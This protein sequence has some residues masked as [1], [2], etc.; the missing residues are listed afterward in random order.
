MNPRHEQ[1]LIARGDLGFFDGLL[2]PA[3]ARYRAALCLLYTS[4]AAEDLLRVALGGRRI[5][6]IKK[7]VT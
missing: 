7:R 6:K 1:A 4:D 3:M 5:I 2:E